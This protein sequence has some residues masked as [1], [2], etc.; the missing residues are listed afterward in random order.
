MSAY[1]EVLEA[2]QKYVASFGSKGELALPPPG[3]LRFSPAWMPGSTRRSTP[4]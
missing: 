1:D 2:N 4:D 3:I